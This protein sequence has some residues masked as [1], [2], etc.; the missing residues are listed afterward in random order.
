MAMAV[1]ATFSPTLLYAS[2][3]SEPPVLIA[4]FAMLLLVSLLYHGRNP[5]GWWAAG[6][7]LG[8]GGM[9]ASGP[10]SISVLLCMT[11][12]FVA[13]Y[14]VDSTGDGAAREAIHGLRGGM[15]NLLILGLTFLGT[16]LV[17]FSHGLSSLSALRGIPETISSWGRM[18]VTS[19]SSSCFTRSWRWFAR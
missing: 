19:E 13:A 7:G 14:L 9:F 1:L 15:S 12:G 10:A 16:L 17:F 3:V 2:R 5:S 11:A 8:L 18:I 4:F 6:V